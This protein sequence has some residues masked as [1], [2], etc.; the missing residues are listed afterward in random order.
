MKAHRFWTLSLV[1]ALAACTNDNPTGLSHVEMINGVAVNRVDDLAMFKLQ[2]LLVADEDLTCSVIRF[3]DF[4]GGRT[5]DQIS[6]G[7]LGEVV[8]VEIDA[9]S[10][11]DPDFDCGTGDLL[12]FDTSIDPGPFPGGVDQD[13]FFSG[14]SVTPNL[15]NVLSHQSCE[16]DGDNGTNPTTGEARFDP[17]NTF[18]PN[19][20]DVMYTMEFTFPTIAG[21]WTIK[22]YTA[23]DQEA[24][25]FIAVDTEGTEAGIT[26]IAA[27]GGDGG[28]EIVDITV[29][30][31]FSTSLDFRFDGSGAIDDIQVCRMAERGGEGC[32]PGY[33]K[34][35]QHFGSWPEEFETSPVD[36]ETFRFDQ[37]FAE[38][39][40]VATQ[41]QRPESGELCDLTLLA[42]LKLKGGGINALGRHAAAAWLNTQSVDFH[43]T[44]LEVETNVMAALARMEYEATKDA[45]AAANEADCPLN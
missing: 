34:Q 25:E 2:G 42:A 29:G 10:I 24:D 23:L 27:I 9:L 26:G 35:T 12:I 33:W 6:I 41:L 14:T 15:G 45:L 3:E 20:A 28:L 39:C 32:T 40:T 38:A 43:Y 4:V 11:V 17:D 1:V 5:H 16:S 7:V 22:N 37:A 31:S 30:G 19:D 21:G 18:I 8:T 36:P 13:L 44:Q